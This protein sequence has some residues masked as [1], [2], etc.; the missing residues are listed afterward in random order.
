M[1]K[2]YHLHNPIVLVNSMGTALQI[3]GWTSPLHVP[4]GLALREQ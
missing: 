4:V 3:Y 2:W 1:M